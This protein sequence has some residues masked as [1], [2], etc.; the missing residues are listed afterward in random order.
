MGQETTKDFFISYTGADQQWAEWIAWQLEEAGFT[1]ILQAWDFQAAGNF[2]LDMNKASTQATRT[3]AVL[4]PAYFTSK[5]TPAEWATA[6]RRDPTGEQGILIPIRVSP[7]DLE[8]LLSSIVYIDLVN[9]DEAAAKRTLLERIPWQRR[10]PASAPSFPSSHS[11]SISSHP[12]FPN[13]R[14]PSATSAPQVA[15]TVDPIADR[16]PVDVYIVCALPKEAQAFLR[17]VEKHCHLS[18]TSEVNCR[19]GYDYRI[20]TLP[21]GKGELLRIHVSWLPRYGPQEM[22]LHLSHV[23][24]ECQPCLVVMTGICAGDKQHVKLGDLIVADRTF[25]YD[26]GKFVD[27][28]HGQIKHQHDTTTYQV[29]ENTLQFLG[30]FEEWKS[31]VAVL[32][33]PFSKLQ[34]RDWLLER[35]FAE[36]TGEVKA[37]PLTELEK[38]A[39][40]W[41]QLVYELQQGPK[42]FLL[43]ELVLRDKAMID[44]LRYGLLPFPFRTHRKLAA[45]SVHSHREARYE[46][47]TRLKISKFQYVGQ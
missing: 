18:W 38:H 19:Y 24:D 31:R 43:P 27:T 33:R 35:L 13:A 21:N 10:K 25:T 2:V 30:L 44:D 1:T 9:L 47:I 32:S 14:T 6:F 3:I 28:E 45:T 39:P 20:A 36:P 41:R 46:V 12:P 16:S 34:Q 23:I 22:L 7:C 8:G 11:A 42:P 29:H 37:I 15:G 5:F 4:S 17:V 26:S 40:A